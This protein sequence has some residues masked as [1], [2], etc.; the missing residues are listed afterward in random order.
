[1]FVRTFL[2][3]CSLMIG[4]WALSCLGTM[5]SWCL[6]GGQLSLVALADIHKKVCT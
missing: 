4:L 6:M 5:Q 2:Y 1:M 3:L